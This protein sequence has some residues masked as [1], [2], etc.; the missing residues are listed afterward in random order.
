MVQAGKRRMAITPPQRLHP[1]LPLTHTHTPAARK[2]GKCLYFVQ[3]VK[4]E[5]LSREKEDRHWG[6]TSRLSNIFLKKFKFQKGL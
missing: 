5:I 3:S 6:K 2:A 1:A 4:T